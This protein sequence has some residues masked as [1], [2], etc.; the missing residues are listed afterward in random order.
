MVGTTILNNGLHLDHWA[1][2]EVGSGVLPSDVQLL[3]YNSVGK[4]K[5]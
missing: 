4:N 1:F 5:E 3:F 2:F